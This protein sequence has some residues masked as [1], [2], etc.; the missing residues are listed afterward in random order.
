[1]I[2]FGRSGGGGGSV[3]ARGFLRGG[4]TGMWGL[5]SRVREEKKRQKALDALEEEMEALSRRVKGLELE[6]ELT[7]EK[8][9]QM[10]G[11]VS[12]RAQIASKAEE[13]HDEAEAQHALAPGEDAI[14]VWQHLTPRQKMIQ[15]QVLGRRRPTNGGM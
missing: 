13:M 3:E 9:H 6:W 12:K 1:M 14:P 11:R 7:Y 4:V 8:I 15:S 5:I 10:L 2:G